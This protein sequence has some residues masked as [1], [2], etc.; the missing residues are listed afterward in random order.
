MARQEA[1]VLQFVRAVRNRDMC[2]VAGSVASTRV[3]LVR[4]CDKNCVRATNLC[5]RCASKSGVAG[6]FRVRG[7]SA[8]CR[9]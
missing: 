2:L 8:R 7:A 9:L 4:L 5:T 1:Q 3:Y 6:R